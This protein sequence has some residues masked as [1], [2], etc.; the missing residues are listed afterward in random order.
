MSHPTRSFQVDRRAALLLP[1]A[2]LALVW[3][4]QNSKPTFN[5]REVDTAEA[6]SL[7]EAGAVV[8]DVREPDK[9]ASRHIAGAVLLPL[10]VLRVGVPL[11]FAF[12]K[13]IQLLVYC[14]DGITHGPEGTALLNK[15]GYANAVNLRPGI[16]GWVAA[17]LPMAPKPGVA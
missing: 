9:Y 13:D 15:A 5:I 3:L 11:S 1:I 7:F 2:G 17:G 16:E 12:A 6:K 10:Q 14:G 8:V 4:S